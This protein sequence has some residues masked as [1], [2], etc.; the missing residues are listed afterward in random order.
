MILK[1]PSNPNHSVIK[2]L[3][4]FIWDMKHSQTVP[5]F[6]LNHQDLALCSHLLTAGTVLW[7]LI[8]PAWL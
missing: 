3:P 2:L 4:T 6:L 5:N 7:L 8:L 1:V